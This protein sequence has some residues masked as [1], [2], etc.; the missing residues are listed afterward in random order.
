MSAIKG[1]DGEDV[2]D[3]EHDVGG[4]DGSDQ[5][6]LIRHRRAPVC[7][8]GEFE[9]SEKYGSEGDVDQRPGGDA[10]EGGAGTLGWI[11]V[12]YA[13][14][15]PEEDGVGFAADG[16]AGEGVSEL[17]EKNDA[18]EGEVFEDVPDGR[19][20]V[21]AAG[22]DFVYGNEEPGPVEVDGDAGNT[23]DTERTLAA[24]HAG[25]LAERGA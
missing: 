1:I 5:T 2:E 15:G 4:E 20:V 13:A 7:E 8:L 10:P 21:A 17:V 19:S 6:V 9:S 25:R 12:G 11:D 22:L 14:K 3:E 16:T 23:K 24:E 18:E